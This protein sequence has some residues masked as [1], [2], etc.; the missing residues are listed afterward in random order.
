MKKIIAAFCLIITPFMLFAKTPKKVKPEDYSWRILE[1]AVVEFDS[2]NF[3]D[4]MTLAL[5][6]KESRKQ[7]S[8]YEYYILNKAV[9]ARPV[10]RVGN[11]FKDVIKILNERDEYEAVNIINHYLDLHGVDFFVENIHHMV[12][13]IKDK[14]V[15]PEA[16]YLLGRIYQLEGEYTVA[17]NY[18]EQ[19]FKNARFLDIPDQKYDIL[20]S[21]ASIAKESGDL[22]KYEN[23]LTL[24]LS[25]NPGFLNE[26]LMNA[27]VRTV[28]NDKAENVDKFFM[29][30]RSESNLTLNALFDISKVYEKQE[31]ADLTFKVYCLGSI[32]SFTHIL[33]SLEERDADYKYS[34]F[35]DF[36]IE[37][38]KYPDI[39]KWASENHVWE[40]FYL[41][42]EESAQNGS[43]LFARKLFYDMSYNCPDS[44]WKAKAAHCLIKN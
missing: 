39:V 7:E 36:L 24:I 33:A 27:C 8:T 6:A 29:L 23:I 9:T 41:L 21:R 10:S 40:F 17:D 31:N 38:S 11:H 4:A 16:D 19:A 3:G 5:K 12:D 37:C 14:A 35:S 30:Y 1:K 43:L 34:T 2:G 32:E 26:T 13:W 15:Y 22:E 25:E 44:Y 18:Y 28:K 20:Y 42:G